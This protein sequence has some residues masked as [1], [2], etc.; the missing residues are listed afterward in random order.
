MGKSHK[1][2]HFVLTEKV[3]FAFRQ[4]GKTVFL[5]SEASGRARRGG[6]GAR[7][8]TAAGCLNCTKIEKIL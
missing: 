1:Y 4:G 7:Q 6:G 5:P 2:R 8:G 3:P